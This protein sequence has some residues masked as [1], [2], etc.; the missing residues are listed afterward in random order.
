MTPVI[1][2][3]NAPKRG[4][5]TGRG[6]AELD[7]DSCRQE[8]LGIQRLQSSGNLGAERGKGTG[9]FTDDGID[10]S[11]ILINLVS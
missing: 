10:G 4:K 11:A 3:P 6:M 2:I 8:E 9:A 1:R 7:S 5:G